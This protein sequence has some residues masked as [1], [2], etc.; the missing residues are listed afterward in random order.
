MSGHTVTRHA[1]IERIGCN[2]GQIDAEEIGELA[3]RGRG[4]HRRANRGRNHARSR[5]RNHCGHGGRTRARGRL[6]HV[7]GHDA[8][9]GAGADHGGEIDPEFLRHAAGVR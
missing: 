1:T 9:I 6:F 5:A 8:T 7:L 4:E 2:G 3:S